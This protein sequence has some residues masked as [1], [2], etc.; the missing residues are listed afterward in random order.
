MI[1]FGSIARARSTPQC[2]LLIL[3]LLA[4]LPL[5]SLRARA[6]TLALDPEV[7]TGVLANGLRYFVRENHHPRGR[8]ELRLVVKAGSILEEPDQQGLAHFVEHMAFNGTRR[9]ERQAIVNYLESIGMR[10]GPDLNAYTGFDETVYMLQLPTDS[11]G[12]LGRGL[13]ILSEW[14]GGIAFDSL[15]IERERGVVIEEWRGARGVEARVRDRQLPVLLRGSRYAERLPIGRT[16]VLDTFRHDRL[17]DFYRDWYRPD[18]MA[19]V[20]VGGFDAAEV[21][22]EIRERFGALPVRSTG[23]VRE[24]YGVPSHEETLVSVVSDPEATRVGAS[25]Y[26]KQHDR[27]IT[28]SVDYRALLVRQLVTSMLNQRLSELTHQA[29]PPFLYAYST[30]TGFTPSTDALVLGAGLDETRIAVGL[31]AVLAEAERARRFGFTVTELERERAEF[32]RSYERAH[33]ERER[34]ESASIAGELVSYFTD[35]DPALGIAAEYELARALL[36][37]ITLEEVSRLPGELMTRGN[38][39]IALA[40]PEKEGLRLPSALELSAILD[41]V[42]S[43]ALEPYVDRSSSEPLMSSLP[44]PGRITR[45]LHEPDLG[46]VHWTLSNGITVIAKPTDFKKDE[47]L[48]VAFGPGGT[49]LVSDADFIDAS[50]ATAVATEGGVGAH[51]QIE[52]QKLLAGRAVSAYPSIGELYEGLS[53]SA[54]PRDL[55][56][57]LQLL[58][59]YVTEPR[60]DSTAVVSFRARGKSSL[61][62]RDARPEAAFSDTLTAILSQYHPRRRPWTEATYDSID[63][64]RAM[65]I[66]RERFADL[67]DFTF[68]VVGALELDTLRPLMERYVGSLPAR[69]RRE[70]WRDVGIGAPGGII[71]RE[72]RRGSEPKARVQLVFGGPFAW[73][74]ANRHEIFAMAGVLEIMLRETLREEKGGTYGV[75]VAA[76][77]GE[78]PRERYSLMISFGCAPERVDELLEQT[79]ATIDSLKA[80]GPSEANL[81]KVREGAR[82]DAEVN[83]RENRYWLGQLQFHIMHDEPF[84]GILSGPRE[85]ERVAT[86]R[87]RAAARR[88]LDRGNV[89]TVMLVPEAMNAEEAP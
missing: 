65:Q 39:V 67:T 60:F 62:N 76:V 88:Y 19:V 47:I 30:Y 89:V 75:G 66:Y 51:S 70:K 86:E 80:H 53:G 82:R 36:P 83:L 5:G 37:S 8:A 58:H 31:S 33:A 40:A 21:E 52:L 87:V 26:F 50:V 69:G 71:K 38:R 3:A 85:F 42:G 74:R 81:Q 35:G 68:I 72:I 6:D 57:M 16:D 23:R 11:V 25:V 15:E 41:S 20:A 43:L 34:T 22:R 63:P 44:T 78:H 77:P 55:E 13:E 59:L 79:F 48:L 2:L 45:E 64:A 32:I 18:L 24:E 17:R 1:G 14:A 12:M 61:R 9:F 84:E 7:R 46:L 56:T 10:F 49:S 4:V 73:S 27:P 29:V 28:T 54:S